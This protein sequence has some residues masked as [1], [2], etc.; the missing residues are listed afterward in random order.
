MVMP[1][2]HESRPK[3]HVCSRSFEGIEE[4]REHVAS[5]HSGA[6]GPRGAGPAPGDV[7]VF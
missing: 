7:S 1:L 6:A 2:V 3:C 4:L 5:E